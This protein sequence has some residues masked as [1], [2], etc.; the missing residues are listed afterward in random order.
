MVIHELKHPIEA[1]RAQTIQVESN[2]DEFARQTASLFERMYTIMEIDQEER[3]ALPLTC[4]ARPKSSHLAAKKVLSPKT[5]L[6]EKIW[7]LFSELPP[8]DSSVDEQFL[9]RVTNPSRE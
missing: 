1:L 8:G 4:S 6:K 3:P 9:V 2:F 5:A 7:S